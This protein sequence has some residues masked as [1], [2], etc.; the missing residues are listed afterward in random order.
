MPAM[1]D[2]GA[3]FGVVKAVVAR[4]V[5]QLVEENQIIGHPERA[6]GIPDADQVNAHPAVWQV[7]AQET[8]AGTPFGRRFAFPVAAV[9]GSLNRIPGLPVAFPAEV[10]QAAAGN[11]AAQAAH[12][13]GAA[14]EAEEVDQVAA[15]V[16]IAQP[17]VSAEDVSGQAQADATTEYSFKE[18]ALRT[19]T[20]VVVGELPIVGD[21]EVVELDDV[22]RAGQDG[23]LLLGGAPGA[24]T[25]DNEIAR[26]DSILHQLKRVSAEENVGFR[27]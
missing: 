27:S 20:R 21:A 14:T 13:V 5:E 8:V 26:H 9:V 18:R 2:Q 23:H 10:E 17:A 1:A 3:E 4:V 19:D 24:I 7:A 12:G 25:A 16:V 15:L 6:D 22:R 11:E